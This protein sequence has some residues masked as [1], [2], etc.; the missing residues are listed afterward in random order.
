[1]P[2][3]I[4]IRERI[5]RTRRNNLRKIVAQHSTIGVAR[6]LGYQSGTFVTQMAGRNPT[7]QVTEGTARRIEEVFELP[8]GEMDRERPKH[9]LLK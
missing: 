3:A 9:R 2:K 7:R 6:F 1:M 8:L 4:P 5:L